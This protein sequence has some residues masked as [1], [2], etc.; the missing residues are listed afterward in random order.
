MNFETVCYA[1]TYFLETCVSR[2]EDGGYASE[3]GFSFGKRGLGEVFLLDF[4]D[5]ADEEKCFVEYGEGHL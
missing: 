1:F 5:G 4:D 3:C 2:T